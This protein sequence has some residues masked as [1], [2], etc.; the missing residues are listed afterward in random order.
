MGRH[1]LPASINYILKVTQHK[2][3]T[4]IGNSFANTL[5]FIAASTNR[6]INKKVE[7]VIALA[8]VASV[9]NS[10]STLLRYV[11]LPLLNRGKVVKLI[12]FF[13]TLLFSFEVKRKKS[14]D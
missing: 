6:E 5:F 11:M 14:F 10:R 4:Y 8:P 7:L 13:N 12:N 9:T 1:D 3:L 2:R